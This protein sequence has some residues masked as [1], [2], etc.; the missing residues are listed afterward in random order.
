MRPPSAPGYQAQNEQTK[1]EGNIS[2]RGRPG[3]DAVG[4]PLGRYQKALAAA[5]GSRW[6]YYVMRNMD[7]IT[8]G[9]VQVRFYVS[10]E[11]RAVNVTVR[12]STSNTAFENFCVQAIT[13]AE[14]PPIPPEVIPCWSRIG[15]K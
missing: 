3:V 4:T 2:N 1:I 14:I 12:D 6:N 11:G 9:S 5:I 7:L 13:A 15:W 8:V 10:R